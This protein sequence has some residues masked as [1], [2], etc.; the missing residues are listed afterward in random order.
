MMVFRLKM[1]EW[2][3]WEEFEFWMCFKVDLIGLI[4]GFNI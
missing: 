4:D 3:L 1:L 2:R